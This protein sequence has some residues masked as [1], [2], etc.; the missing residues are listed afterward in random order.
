MAHSGG[1][2]KEQYR[3]GCGTAHSMGQGALDALIL[4]LLPLQR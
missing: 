1:D 4:F 2:S 3:E